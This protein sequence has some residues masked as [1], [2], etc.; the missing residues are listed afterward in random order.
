MKSVTKIYGMKEEVEKVVEGLIFSHL[1]IQRNFV[2]QEY[3]FSLLCE[4]KD[5]LHHSSLPQFTKSNLRSSVTKLIS[6]IKQK[7]SL[8]MSF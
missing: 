7:D 2:N 4:F 8:S 1:G 6:A 3:E 5:V